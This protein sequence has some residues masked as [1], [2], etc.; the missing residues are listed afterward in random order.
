[1]GRRVVITGLGVISPVGIE[2]SDFWA[3]LMEGRSGVSR[4]ERFD[5]SDMDVQIGGEV[6][7]FDPSRWFGRKEARHL[8]RFS[9]FALA[10]A[11]MA[12]EDAGLQ[13]DDLDKD[14]TGVILGSGIGGLQELED[15]SHKLFERGPGRVSPFFVPKMMINAAPG[16]VAIRWGVRG[17]NFATASAC[18]ASTHAL[19]VA[20]DAIRNGRADVIISGGS[21]AALLR[22]GMAGFC[23]LKALSRRNDEPEKA[24]RPFE[25]G[26]D[27]FVLGEGAGVLVL[28]T[29]ENAQARGARI[30]AEL[31]GFG[32]SD[33]GHHITAPEPEG[34]GMSRAMSL[35]LK[36]GGLLPEQV[37]YINAH[38]TSTQLNDATETR[39][40]R[41]VFGDHAASLAVSS[42]KSMTGHLL[43]GAGG[44]E[45]VVSALAV[46]H[47]RV[48]PTINYDE[49]DP[50]C[51]LD[52]VPNQARD[53][54]V[55]VALSN[56][57]GFGG[58]NASLVFGRAP[59]ASEA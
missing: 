18:A 40:I 37:S 13:V 47:N 36:D 39:A 50:D 9:Q 24:S 22:L 57:F 45:A 54:A 58:H 20:L 7:D 3:S 21:E 19:G 2:L 43:G 49:A 30:Y 11:E 33:D 48:P 14:R 55:E 38:G 17:P 26:R 28:E 27:G 59:S 29:L 44:L 23:S 41:Q 46:H 6:K 56:S 4:V 42:T 1:M 25:N 32:M 8:D 15:Q 35:A 5:V 16:Q 31:L 53:L 52:Y 10:A 12:R 51:D 34:Y